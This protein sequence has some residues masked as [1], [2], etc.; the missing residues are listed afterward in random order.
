MADQVAAVGFLE[1]PV[2]GYLR[3]REQVTRLEAEAARLLGMIDAEGL[4]EDEGFGSAAGWLRAHGDSGS[5]AGRRVTGARQ[6]RKHP[7]VAEAFEEAAIDRPRVGLLLRAA[8]VSQELFE[9]DAEMLVDSVAGLSYD[10]AR[11]VTAYWSQAADIEAAETN[12]EHL[13]QRRR[14]H[15]SQT[16]GGMVRIDG[17]L[18]PEN[19]ETVLTALRSITDPQNL[20]D[21]DTRSPAQ[22]RAD[23]LVDL[24]ADHL[25]HGNTPTTGG[26]KP[27]LSVLVNTDTLAG[28]AAE[29][30]ETADGTVITPQT[31]RRIACDAA[32]TRVVM[33]PK[34]EI[35]DVGRTTRVVPAATRTALVAR[36]RHCTYPGCDRPHRWCDAHHITHWADGGPTNLNNLTLL[37][38]HHHHR[39]HTHGWP[40]TRQ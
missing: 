11:R 3:L 20:D 15:V 21:T 26:Q 10:D 25:T 17:E 31:A 24:C 38:R 8:R 22:K 9:R 19:G 27:H 6:L 18:D 35:I 7:Q 12:A 39:I 34:S 32:I 36:D 14:L 23:A 16:L 13:Y 33:G 37:C 29:P 1:S 2:E 30:C 4:Y 28:E 40:H 5:E